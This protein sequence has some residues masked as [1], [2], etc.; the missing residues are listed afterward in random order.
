M[1]LSSDVTASEAENFRRSG[2]VL[3]ADVKREPSME[4][5][6][7]HAWTDDVQ[8]RPPGYG[9]ARG[10]LVEGFDVSLGGRVQDEMPPLVRMVTSSDVHG[11]TPEKP[12]PVS[13]HATSSG[14][15]EQEPTWHSGVKL[16]NVA[17][18][19]TEASSGYKSC[20]DSV[21]GGLDQD[22]PG[23]RTNPGGDVVPGSGGQANG[24]T[25]VGHRAHS[26]QKSDELVLSTPFGLFHR[27]PLSFCWAGGQST[28]TSCTSTAHS[29]SAV[30]TSTSPSS[31][32]CQSRFPESV[33]ADRRLDVETPAKVKVHR[34]LPLDA[35]V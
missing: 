8:S 29:G 3:S 31:G 27:A 6:D 26:R 23:S 33:S 22:V 11:R 1:H 35:Y 10:S 16:G 34:F 14:S 12:H 13:W 15:F 18:L 19:G 4:I 7:K 17:K 9:T 24:M 2:E 32:K 5:D 28:G 25:V 30:G 21:D 20:L